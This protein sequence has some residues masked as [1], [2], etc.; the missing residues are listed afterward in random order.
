MGI[1]ISPFF[2]N[3]EENTTCCLYLHISNY[4]CQLLA[5]SNISEKLEF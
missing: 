1:A 5:S 4:L 2:L 3:N